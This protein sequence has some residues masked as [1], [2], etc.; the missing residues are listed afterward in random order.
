MSSTTYSPSIDQAAKL[1]FEQNY[2][3][4][5][6]Q[7]SSKLLGSGAIEFVPSAGKTYHKTRIGKTELVEVNTRNPDKQYDDWTVDGRKF[8]KRRFTKTFLIDAKDDINELI[9]DPTSDIL[10]TIKAAQ[11]RI[12]DRIAISAAIG[13]VTVG[14]PDEAGSS[15][16][17]ATDG[18]IT[19][20]ASSTGVT[21]DKVLEGTENFVNNDVPDQKWMNSIFAI[22]GAENT[23]LMGEVEFINNDY[24]NAQP[25]AGKTMSNVA[26]Y[27][28]AL[29]AGSQNGGISVT[30]PI[31]PE[32]STTRTCVLMAPGAVTMATELARLD[33]T[34]SAQKV[35]SYEITIDYWIN[36]MRT[37]GVLVQKYTTTM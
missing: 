10:M 34:K 26:G 15:I 36:A 11:E 21:Y 33:V 17:A 12:V 14:A 18:V 2:Y 22:T 6:Q 7:M 1:V 29:F 8:T 20:D 13:N 37:E 30:N 24:M 5:S 27:R 25:L 28:I 32:G 35:N 4:L 23:D 16:T 3:M 19:V 9:K 31:L